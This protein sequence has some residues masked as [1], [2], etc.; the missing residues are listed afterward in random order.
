MQWHCG[1]GWS[2][3]TTGDRYGR[4]E[5]GEWV[6]LWKMSGD[7]FGGARKGFGGGRTEW[8]RGRGGRGA[9]CRGGGGGGGMRRVKRRRK[10]KRER[11]EKGRVETESKSISTTHSKYPSSQSLRTLTGLSIYGSRTLLPCCRPALC[12]WMCLRPPLSTASAPL[13]GLGRTSI[14]CVEDTLPKGEHVRAPG[15]ADRYTHSAS[16][17]PPSHNHGLVRPRGPC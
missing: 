13:Q 8:M 6:E 2:L 17:A 5:S 11:R 3:C 4:Q 12:C 16:T 14:H 15:S 7:G 1:N 9:G 10:R